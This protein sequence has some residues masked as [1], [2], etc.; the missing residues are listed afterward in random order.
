MR[1]CACRGRRLC[2]RLAEQAKIL[3]AEAEENNLG[4]EVLQE[5]WKR[6]YSCSLCEQQYHSFVLGALGWACWPRTWAK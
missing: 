3:V 2:A 1:G 6:W 5:R 4:D